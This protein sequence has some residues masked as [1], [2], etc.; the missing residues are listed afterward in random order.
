M[1]KNIQKMWILLILSFPLIVTGCA[2]GTN[3][4][5]ST[6]SPTETPIPPPATP[7]SLPIA[8]R[9]NGAGI[10]LSDYQEEYQRLDS[11]LK[12]L[13]KTLSPDEMKAKVLDDLIGTEILN[14][15]SKKNGYS[16]SDADITTHID[17]LAQAMGGDDAFKAWKQ[18]MF[19]SDESFRRFVIRSLG[20]VWQRDQIIKSLQ[21]TA[22]QVH[23][24]QIL[25]TRE[26][27]A[28]NYR[29]KVDSGSDFAVLAKEADPVTGGELGWFPKGYLLQSEVEEA[30][31]GLQP[32]EV[33]R[34]IKSAIGYHLI[35][36]IEK[37]AARLVEPDAKIILQRKAIVEWV[38]KAK[39]KSQIE[40][41]IS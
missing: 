24:R 29:Q 38:E 36:V 26:E 16:I 34:V 17:Q 14:L 8:V 31:F 25:F 32:G 21:G 30:A 2:V 18:S 5:V 39:I 6:S 22:E 28:V 19:Y 41:L 37:D 20:S 23:A 33:S 11:G 4:P 12:T 13:G 10:L 27:S 1:Y 40:I 7:T 15:E 9:I 35:Q 3:K